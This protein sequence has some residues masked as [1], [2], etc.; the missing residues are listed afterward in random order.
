M[1]SIVYQLV[2]QKVNSLT[3]TE[4]M[5]LASQYNI[6]LNSSQAQKVIAILRSEKIDVSNTAQVNRIINRLKKEVDPYVSSV[7]NQLLN[8]FG[9]YLK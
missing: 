3:K 5:N 6:P 2:N 8:E 9:H 7:V 4:L 1:N